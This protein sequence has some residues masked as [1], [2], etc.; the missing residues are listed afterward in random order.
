MNQ[1]R[2][3]NNPNPPQPIVIHHESQGQPKPGD[4]L[5]YTTKSNNNFYVTV[6]SPKLANRF[7]YGSVI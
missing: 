6:N 5:R 2:Q 1:T 7:S 3:L 4:E